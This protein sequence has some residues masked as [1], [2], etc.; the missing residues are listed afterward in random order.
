MST[1]DR[2]LVEPRRNMVKCIAGFL[3]KPAILFTIFYLGIN[4]LLNIATKLSLVVGGG[5]GHI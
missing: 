5:R 2:W 4:T 3:E 1:P